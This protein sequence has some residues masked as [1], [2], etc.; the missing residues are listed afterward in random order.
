MEYEILWQCRMLDRV[1]YL[2]GEFHEGEP[3]PGVTLPGE[4]NGNPAGLRD[5]CARLFA[6]ERMR[7]VTCLKVE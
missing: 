2:V 3:L 7:I 5:R 6:P 4:S 1:D